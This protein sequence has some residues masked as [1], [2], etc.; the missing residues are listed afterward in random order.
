LDGNSDRD[1]LDGGAF[2]VFKPDPVSW[3]DYPDMDR[4]S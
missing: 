1:L 2:A 4:Y 3:N